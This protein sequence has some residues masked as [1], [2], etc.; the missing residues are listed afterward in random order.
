MARSDALWLDSDVILK[1]PPDIDH[2]AL[3]QPPPALLERRQSRRLETVIHPILSIF[4][5]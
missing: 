5:H 2:L 3:I 1:Y 4:E